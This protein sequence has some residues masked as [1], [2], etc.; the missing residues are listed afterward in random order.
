MDLQLKGKTAFVSGSSSG[1]GL[2]IAL[3]LAA[4]GCD[5]VVHGRDK[6]R[7]QETARQVQ[8][9]GVRAAITLGDLAVE[10]E[11]TAVCDAALA[12]FLVIQH[13]DVSTQ[14]RY[15]PIIRARVAEGEAKPAWFA[16]LTDRILVAKGKPQV[17]GTQS[18]ANPETGVTEPVE[19]GDPERVNE[20][21]ALLGL[22]PLKRL[23]AN[24]H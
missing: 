16:L 9:K 17:Y 7:A 13:A 15:L 8:A 21:R 19:I 18:R 5:V 22:K 10:E 4:E 23:S 12:A 24:A 3:E 14:E 1:I 11:A 20:R 6:A 2:G